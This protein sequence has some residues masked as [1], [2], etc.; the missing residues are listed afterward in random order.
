M[1]FW[2][3]FVLVLGV[4]AF[5]S[6]QAAAQ[7]L[8]RDTEIEAYLYDM[9]EPI[10]RAAGLP[11]GG[12]EILLIGD[13]SLNA[14][15][16]A[17]SGLKMGVHTGLISAADTPNQIEGVIA[18]EAGHLAGGHSART[19][20]VF[21]KAGKQQMLGLLL[22]AALIAAGAP[23]EAGFGAIGLGQAAAMNNYLTYSRGQESAAD[24]A[25]INYLNEV[26]HSATGL[27]EFFGKLQNQQLIRAGEVVP[28]FQTHPLALQR[29]SRLTER[30]EASPFFT[31]RDDPEKIEELR[32]IQ[33]KIHGFL[34][35]PHV[36]LRRFPLTDQSDAARYARAV[37][38]YRASDL[39]SATREIDRLLASYPDN[40]Y[41]H[42]LKGQMLFEHGKVAQ[43][44]PSHRRSVELMPDAPLLRVNLARALVATEMEEETAEAV[45]L[46]KVALRQERDNAFGWSLL[47]RGYATLGRLDQANLAQAETAYHSGDVLSAHRFASLAKEKLPVGTPEHQQAL[48]I[49]V[50]TAEDARR[51]NRGPFGRPR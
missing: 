32:L 50:A 33:A 38:Y 7:V 10:W 1:A 14:F 15:A 45:E 17:S 42:E 4:L 43:S 31:V 5:V 18:H 22:G 41:Y 3:S 23:P 12:V 8:L 29:I 11:E 35:E 40:P 47:A 6:S 16:G 34:D 9:S 19:A 51:L 48:D 27:L 39:A 24:Q 25:A 13:P 28:Y 21:A 37:A 46:L 36:A 2:R 30:A 44:I 20:D 26:G 49:L